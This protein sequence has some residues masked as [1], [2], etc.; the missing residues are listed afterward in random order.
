MASASAYEV[1]R[2]TTA[3][4]SNDAPSR[5][6][7][8]SVTAAEP[9]TGRSASAASLAEPKGPE[10]PIAVAVAT[11]IEML[12]TLAKTEPDTESMRMSLRSS[13]PAPRST[14]ALAW[15]SCM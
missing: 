2:G 5:P 4:A 9:A 1:A 12:M 7:A 13:A 11:M 3:A 14:T 6:T 15:Y 8:K 10:P